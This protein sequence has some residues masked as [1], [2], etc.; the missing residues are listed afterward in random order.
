M[1]GKLNTDI[2]SQNSHSKQV[3]EVLRG[4]G[5]LDLRHHLS[6][7]GGS[8]TGNGVSDMEQKIFGEKSAAK[9]TWGD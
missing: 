3:A 5:L 2:Q 7:A 1:L 4:F 8:D 6:R 9:I